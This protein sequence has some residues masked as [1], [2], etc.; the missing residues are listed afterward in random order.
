MDAGAPACAQSTVDRDRAGREHVTIAYVPPR[1]RCLPP[2]LGADFSVAEARAAGLTNR[3]LRAKDLDVPYRGARR[4]R[5]EDKTEHLPENPTA[6]AATVL[7]DEIRRNAAAF[8]TI[9]RPAMFFSHVTAAVIWGLPLPLRLLVSPGVTIDDVLAAARRRDAASLR[10]LAARI[11]VA[12]LAPHRASKSGS[13]SGRRLSGGLTH[14]RTARGFR[15]SS[16]ATT[17]A[18]LAALLTVDGLIE[19]GDAL[20]FIPRRRGLERG[21]PED[22]LATPAQLTAAIDAG[23]R[24][25]IHRLREALPQIR[26]GSASP[27]ETKVRLACVRAGLPEPELDVDVVPGA[28][29]PIGCTEI[30]YREWRVLVENEG[31]HHRTDTAQWD[32]DIEKYAA[33]EAAG[34]TIVRLTGR[35]VRD[36]AH[37]AVTKVRD[38]LVRAGW[39]PPA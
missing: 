22:A 32:R 2:G 38:A 31:D 33:C 24:A 9:A 1:P 10:G 15:V 28:A 16:P 17:W 36:N 25:G 8:M 18:Q 21:T 26:V 20:V 29:K 13:V 12:V 11:D 6:F 27:S 35:H 7:A 34:W 23:P 3:R 4:R 37:L 30:V 19:V 39:R 14:V 5:T